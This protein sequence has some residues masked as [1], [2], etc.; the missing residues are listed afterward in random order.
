MLFKAGALNEFFSL[1]TV[2]APVETTQQEHAPIEKIEQPEKNLLEVQSLQDKNSFIFLNLPAGFTYQDTSSPRKSIMTAAYEAPVTVSI[3]VQRWSGQWNAED[4]MYKKIAGF[5][6][7]QSGRSRISI[8]SH[9]LINMGGGQGYKITSAETVN[10]SLCMTHFYTLVGHQKIIS[11]QITCK[12]C[13]QLKNSTLFNKVDEAIK[14][15]L[16]IYP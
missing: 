1:T 12:N 2:S 5:Q 6:D 3:E 8:E 14:K 16:L 9:A 15:S 4:E 7:G 10:A 11:I 13:K